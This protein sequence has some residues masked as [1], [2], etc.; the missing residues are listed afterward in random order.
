MVVLLEDTWATPTPKSWVFIKIWSLQTL[1][2]PMRVLAFLPTRKPV[3]G[4]G[5]VGLIKHLIMLHLLPW[6]SIPKVERKPNHPKGNGLLKKIGNHHREKSPTTHWLS[7]YCI[8]EKSLLS[9]WNHHGIEHTFFIYVK[10]FC[11]CFCILM[12]L[13]DLLQTIDSAGR[14]AWSS[15]MVSHCSAAERENRE[16]VQGEMA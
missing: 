13:I 10:E 6:K 12:I 2:S 5:A 1:L 11:F 4:R 7:D 9:W 3:E 14:E 16:A 15:E 8:C